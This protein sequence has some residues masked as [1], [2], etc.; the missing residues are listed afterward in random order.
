M[1]ESSCSKRIGLLR[2]LFLPFVPEGTEREE[3]KGPH[4]PKLLTRSDDKE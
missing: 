4:P 1:V 2:M 3:E